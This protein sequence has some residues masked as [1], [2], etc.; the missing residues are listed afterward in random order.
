MQFKCRNSAYISSDVTLRTFQ[1][2]QLLVLVKWRHSMCIS[3][4]VTMC[5]FQVMSLCVFFKSRHC[6]HFKCQNFVH[7]SSNVTPC[8]LQMTSLSAFQAPELCTHFKLRLY[9]H[10]LSDWLCIFQVTSLHVHFKWCHRVYIS[11][12]VTP[13]TFQLHSISL[14]PAP[15]CLLLI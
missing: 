9:A 2:S 13:C 12:N 14:V 11:S 15:T 4:H 8:T 6:V 3:N 7:I 1:V 5:T 10:I